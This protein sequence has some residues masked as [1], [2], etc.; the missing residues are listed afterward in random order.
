MPKLATPGKVEATV[1]GKVAKLSKMVVKASTSVKPAAKVAAKLA[2]SPGSSKAATVGADADGEVA[3]EMALDAKTTKTL[4]NRL[5]MRPAA[6]KVA[7]AL[8]APVGTIYIGHLPHGFY[9]EQMRP[10]F[11]QFGAVNRLRVSRAKKTGRA[12]GYAYV[13]FEEPE[14]ARIV[15]DAMDGYLMFEKILRVHTLT[16]EKVHATLWKG[17]NKPFKTMNFHK[18]DAAKVNKERSEA[19]L[20]AQCSKLLTKERRTKR[21][22]A[23]AGIEYD[24]P[25]YANSSPAA[26]AGGAGPSAAG[27][28]RAA[29]VEPVAGSAKKRKAGS[30]ADAGAAAEAAAAVAKGATPA[31]A[32]APKSAT[33]TKSATPVAAA[34]VAVAKGTP[35]ATLKPAAAAGGTAAKAAPATAGKG[36]SPV[37]T[38]GVKGT[39][40][41]AAPVSAA[42]AAPSTAT[43]AA[44]ASVA[45][46]AP[47]TATKAAPASVGKGRSPVG[48]RGVTCTPA[49]A[50]PETAAVAAPSTVIE[51][52][53]ASVA[54]AVLSTAIKA[55]PASVAKVAPASVA[56]AALDTA[57]KA[58]PPTAGKQRSP[59]GTRARKVTK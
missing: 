5:K 49:K 25:G 52:A 36:R 34:E 37:G 47:S 33:S 17:A 6:K 21:K 26:V 16:P 56:K 48:T 55:A 41:K 10:F 50:A 28:K 40:A 43:K 32:A 9:E 31:K 8:V 57:A 23:E 39:P 58:A 46:A 2:K 45:K 15:A 13:E 19:E 44:P 14:V 59:V 29:P 38:R 42:V 24:F 3:R 27:A 53:P 11:E 22:L 7:P 54:K 4:T 1:E 12:K 20:G 35:K 18:L 51:V 30:P